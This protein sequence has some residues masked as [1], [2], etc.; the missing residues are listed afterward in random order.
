MVLDSPTHSGRVPIVLG[1]SNSFWSDPNHFGQV[2]ITKISPKKSNLNPTK[3]IWT[4]PKQF[5]PVQT[6]EDKTSH[7]FY[8]LR[9]FKMFWTRPKKIGPVQND[10]DKA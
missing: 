8:N 5:V 6:I 3:T 1:G 7:N 4:L 2:L 9:L 10:L